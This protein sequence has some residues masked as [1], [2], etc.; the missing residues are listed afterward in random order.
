MKKLGTFRCALILVMVSMLL[1]ARPAAGGALPC[2]ILM[3][4]SALT[5]R[6]TRLPRGKRHSG[7][8]ATRMTCTPGGRTRGCLSV[9]RCQRSRSEI[10]MP[11]TRPVLA[12]GLGGSGA[13]PARHPVPAN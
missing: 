13:S 8:H 2:T 6:T 10:R 9:F 11:S 4:T 3:R 7:R 5:A 12:R 1:A